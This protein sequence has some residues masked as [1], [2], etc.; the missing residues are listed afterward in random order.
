[1]NKNNN[2]LLIGAGFKSKVILNMLINKTAHVPKNIKFKINNFYNID[3][4]NNKPKDSRIIN[5]SSA[6]DRFKEYIN[7]C[8]YFFVCFSGFDNFQRVV[9]HNKL[10]KKKLRPINILSKYCYIDETTQIGMGVNINHNVTV[11]SDCKIG[12]NVILNTSSTI[13]HDCVIE[14]GAH[15]MGSAAIAGNVHIKKYATIGTNSTILPN[16][17]IGKNA[18][19]GAG[20][21]IRKNVGDNDIVVGSNHR[22]IKKNIYK[23]YKFFKF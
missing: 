6:I 11:N 10:L 4:L 14:D 23:K 19:V 3:Y 18:I 12:N 8:N 5:F 22:I 9:I 20:A 15:I 2:I 13:D 1:M 17:T 21:I 16:I 7:K